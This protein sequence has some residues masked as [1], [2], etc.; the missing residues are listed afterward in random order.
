MDGALCLFIEEFAC[1]VMVVEEPPAPP[2]FETAA[3]A[4]EFLVA[5]G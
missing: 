1:V 5:C 2:R 3:S 4:V